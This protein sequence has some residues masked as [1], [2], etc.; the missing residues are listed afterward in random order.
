MTSLRKTVM[1]YVTILLIVVGFAAATTSYYVVKREVNSFQDNA[2]QEVALTAGLIFRNDI[3]PRIDA[4]LEDQLVVQVWDHSEKPLHRSGP[5]VEIP[6]QSELGYSNVSAGGERWRVFRAR[7]AQHAIQIS[8]RWSA[9][10]EVAAHAAMGAAAPLIVAV[11][12]AWL[13]IGWA[14]GRILAGLGT[15]STDISRRSVDAK[16]ALGMAGVP[17]EITPLVGAMNTLIERHQQALETQR[18]FV[19]DAAHELRTPLAAIQIQVDNLQAQDLPKPTREASVDLLNGIRRATYSVY[20]LLVMTRADASMESQVDTIEAAVLVQ[21]TVSAAASIA[22]TKG[23]QLIMAV[24]EGQVTVRSSEVQLVLSNL[25]D[26]AVRYTGPGG[27]VHVNGKR[28]ENTFEIKVIDTGCGIPGAALPHIYD[29][30]F[31]AAPPDIEGTGLGLAIAK[32]A[33]DRSGMQIRIQNRKDA[34]GVVA[35]VDIPLAAT[36]HSAHFK[37]QSIG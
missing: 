23:V 33:A 5:P 32:A 36:G 34:P 10:E 24:E 16:D 4:E 21:M 12:L 1:E 3:Q 37:L 30:F 7:D 22:A 28:T 31:R 13:M 18:R 15:L 6:S 9:R 25:V 17:D 2:L 14:V 8:Q 26:N 20:Q 27:Q 29:R 11:P 19:S 35:T